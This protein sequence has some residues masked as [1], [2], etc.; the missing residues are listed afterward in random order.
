[1]ITDYIED[2]F[3][4]ISDAESRNTSR[5]ARRASATS[6]RS[7]PQSSLLGTVPDDTLSEEAWHE[8]QAAF[9]VG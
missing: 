5:T 8:L 2:A 3:R 6:T 1:M 9:R 7:G 4:P